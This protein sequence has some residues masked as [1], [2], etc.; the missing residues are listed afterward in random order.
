ME[1]LDDVELPEPGEGACGLWASGALA[2]DNSIHYMPHN[3]HRIMKLNPDNDSLSSVGDYLGEGFKCSG[4]VVGNDDCMYGIPSYDVTRIIKFDPTSPDST[5][6]VGEQA[7]E[8][9]CGDK[10][11]LAGD[12]YI[13]A[14]HDSGQVLKVDTTRNNYTWIG[15]RIYDSGWQ[16]QG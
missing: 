3:A 15:D 8:I 9:E 14:A 12:G 6:T 1:T 4:T 2:T 10:G 7:D 16:S 5:S 13:Y 11:V